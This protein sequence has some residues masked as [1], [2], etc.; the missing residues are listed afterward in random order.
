M[1][2]YLFEDEKNLIV[3]LTIDEFIFIF[4]INREGVGEE[5]ARFKEETGLFIDEEVTVKLGVILFN[6]IEKIFKITCEIFTTNQEEDVHMCN[7]GA[8]NLTD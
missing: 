1:Q 4:E 2:T 8:G 5:E 3:S 7:E 6:F